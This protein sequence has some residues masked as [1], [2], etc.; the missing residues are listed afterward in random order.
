[1]PIANDALT[2]VSQ[3]DQPSGSVSEV[4]RMALK[5]GVTAFGGPA[6]HVAMLR[7]EIV[8]RRAWMTDAFFLDLLAATNL[9]PGPN[10]TEMVIH[11][12]F[13]RAGLR[14]LL[15]AGACFIL[16]AALITLGFAWVYEQYGTTPQLESFLYGVKPV[17]IAVVV[18]AIWGLGRTIAN[19][20][21]L[22]AVSVIAF[23]LSLA[24]VN[25]LAVLFGLGIAV[26][27]ARVLSARGA[28]SLLLITPATRDLL[29]R[30]PELA[31]ALAAAAEPYSPVR[32]FLNFLKIGATLYGT[33]YVLLPFMQ[34]DFVE[35]LGWLT[36][37]QLLDAV[38]VG[39]FTPGPVFTTATF[40]GYLIGGWGGAT[41]ATI[42][43]FL[44]AFFLVGFTHP[45]VPKLRS[46]QWAAAFFGRCERR[47]RRHDG[48]SDRGT[49]ASG[50]RRFDDHRSCR[51]RGPSPHPLPSQFG[52]AD[53]RGRCAGSTLAANRILIDRQLSRALFI[54]LWITVAT[55]KVLFP[56]SIWIDMH[57]PARLASV[58]S[59]GLCAVR[60]RLLRQEGAHAPRFPQVGEARRNSC[61]FR[62][63]HPGIE[64]RHR[65][66][67]WE[68]V[69]R[70]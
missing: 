28:G 17:V 47:R 15:A 30:A 8:T 70:A 21:P 46:S 53:C 67:G 32:L 16:P 10:S 57:P 36:E 45:F 50:A 65:G 7:E 68:S 59:P 33:G 25:E 35:T 3:Q 54:E 49:R 39:Q 62:V 31:T 2:S 14:G 19:Q 9:I 38:A 69:A 24:G 13:H 60:E 22:V 20:V 52:L 43:I 11:A 18:H 55:G 26:M 48:L 23:P 4:A 37:Q 66:A 51:T 34:Q 40:V 63:D 29:H 27:A 64:Y 61:G 56:G 1:M 58:L 6:A 44:P 42:G 12:G 41:L 5:L